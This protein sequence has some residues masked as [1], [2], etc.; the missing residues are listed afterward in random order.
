MGR[1]RGT[2]EFDPCEPWVLGP[3]KGLQSR[4]IEGLKLDYYTPSGL[5]TVADL[6]V[7]LQ[8]FIYAEDG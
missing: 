3:L 6:H 1:L 2:T 8:K 5:K 7:G 4:S